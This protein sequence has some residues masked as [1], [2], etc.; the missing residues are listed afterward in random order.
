MTNSSTSSLAKKNSGLLESKVSGFPG[1]KDIEFSRKDLE[2]MSIKELYR[3]YRLY[4]TQI[5]K[6][7]YALVGTITKPSKF[8]LEDFGRRSMIVNKIAKSTK[9]CKRMSLWM[10]NVILLNQVVYN[11]LVLKDGNEEMF[12]DTEES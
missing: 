2:E 10:R 6:D 4:N 7:F 11:R 1:F 8:K 12:G 9:E 3:F 5:V